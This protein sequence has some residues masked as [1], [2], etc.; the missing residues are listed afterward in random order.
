MLLHLFTCLLL[1][2]AELAKSQDQTPQERID[3]APEGLLT[4]TE[5][6]VRIKTNKSN[7][8]CF[9]ARGCLFESTDDPETPWCFFP[10][11]VGYVVDEIKTINK[12]TEVKLTRNKK[13]R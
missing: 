9:K 10:L 2:H 12:H 1:F 11:D 8:K 4:T 5:C 13:Y 6:K 7:D 3:C